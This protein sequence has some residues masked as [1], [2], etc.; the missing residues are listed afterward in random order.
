MF[1]FRKTISALL[2]L[3]LF[4][5]VAVAQELTVD[6]H[7]AK[8]SAVLSDIQDKTG[9]HFV[10]NNSLVDVST[11]VTATASGSLRQV[12]DSVL[13]NLPVEY[14]IIDKQIILSPVKEKAKSGKTTVSGVVVDDSGLPL[15]GVFVQEKG[16]QN[17]TSSDLDGRYSL[18]VSQSSTLVFSCLGLKESEQSVPRSGGRLDVQM[19]SD[20]NYL[21]EVVIVGYGV[22]KRANLTGAVSTIIFSDGVDSRP[23]T[24]ASNA[25][26]GLAPGLA[27]TQTSGQPGED[28]ATLRVRGN[29]TLNTNSPLVLVDGIEYSMDN[30]NPQDI[31]SIT[32]LKDASSTAIF[33]SPPKA[34]LP[35]KPM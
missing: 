4:S 21:D 13:G 24:T 32:V 29:T 28:G 34:E 3:I 27:V 18:T 10:Y 7:S 16:T 2:F 20:V 35:G 15:P 8:L 26:G 17:G 1:S 33:G 19:S 25:L 31:E 5:V 11:T 23:I 30:I 12:L 22:Q 6:Y 9:Y 14:E